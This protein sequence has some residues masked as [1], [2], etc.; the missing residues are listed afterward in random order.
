MIPRDILQK[1]RRIEIRTKGLV[2]DL[3]GGEYHSVFKGQGMTFAE[4]RDYQPGD[5]IRLIDWNVTARYGSP[6]VKI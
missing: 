6:Y 4:V 1:V 2:N 5:D 3:F